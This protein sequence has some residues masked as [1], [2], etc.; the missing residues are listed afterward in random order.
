MKK[1]KVL[2]ATF[3][4]LIFNST[5]V[6]A[7]DQ[8]LSHLERLGKHLFFDKNLSTPRGQSC[9]ICHGKAVGFTGPV[10]S[11]NATIAIYP[12]A[13]HARFGNRKPPS[14]A[15]AGDSPVLTYD[16][17]S[18]QWIGGMFW[19]GRATGHV[20]GDPLAEQAQG[21][22]LNPLEQNNANAKVVC[23]K[24]RNSKYA[25][26][27]EYVW[28]TGSL[29]CARDVEDTYEKIARSIAAYERSKEVN[30]FNSKY[31]RYLAGKTELSPTEKRGLELFEG[32][33]KCAACH[34]NRPDSNDN[35]PLFTDFTYDNLGVPRNP[36]NPFYYMSPKWNPIG[37]NWIDLG[38][39]GYLK[40]AGYSPDVYL[41][42]LGKMKV[43]TLRNV[44]KKPHFGFVKAFAHNGYF[45]SLKQII[46][47]YNT[48][49]VLPACHELEI[50]GNCWPLPEIAENINI[51]ELGDL[52]LTDQEEDEIVAFLRTLSDL[53]VD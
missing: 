25:K 12:G 31:D 15:Y 28:G 10:S 47:F 21:P 6:D 43:P 40:N 46:H 8:K 45:K 20:L 24:V 2:V 18:N 4:I 50:S 26:L 41:P 11:I 33:G 5:V 44:A 16:L 38:L 35:P 7:H 19:D 42:E 13:A 39:G 30:S 49:D 36:L 53:D 48:R 37:F 17:S 27:F 32:K 23:V 34:I 1:I 22:F 9:A 51:S 3:F 14:S 52:G 29:T